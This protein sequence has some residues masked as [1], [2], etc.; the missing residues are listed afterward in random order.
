MRWIWHPGCSTCAT[1]GDKG[2]RWGRR[3]ELRHRRG[4]GR[5]W[6]RSTGSSGSGSST[7][8]GRL[9]SMLELRYSSRPER[10]DLIAFSSGGRPPAGRGDDDLE[11]IEVR[12]GGATTGARGLAAAGLGEE[13]RRAAL[14]SSST[15]VARNGPTR[16]RPSRGSLLHPQEKGTEGKVGGEH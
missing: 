2:W 11:V 13:R 16:Q 10:V 8:G 3:A 15:Q 9:R 1:G 12:S 14:A 7:C 6:Q 4:G 5:L